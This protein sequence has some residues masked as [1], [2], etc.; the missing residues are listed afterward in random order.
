MQENSARR[1]N[2]SDEVNRESLAISNCDHI[3]PEFTAD[4]EVRVGGDHSI[5]G[6]R[7]SALRCVASFPFLSSSRRARLHTT[8]GQGYE[9][10]SNQCTNPSHRIEYQLMYSV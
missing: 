9:P 5:R 6:R 2:T 7:R 4:V 3:L 1:V 8:S 10:R